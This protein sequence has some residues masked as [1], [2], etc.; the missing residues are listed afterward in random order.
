MKVIID[1]EINRDE[2]RD[3][4]K[5]NDFSTPFQTPEFFDFFN[6]VPG[7][8]ASVFA[9]YS[10][11]Q[12]KVIS[13]VTMQKEIGLFS[14]FSRR[15]IIY[16][17]PVV[18]R[19]SEIELETLFSYIN[20]ALKNKIIYLE[21]RNFEDYGSFRNSF[22]KLGW[23]YYPH[24][25]IQIKLAGKSLDSLF[26]EMKYNR[27]REIRISLKE[28][29]IYKE[30]ET[31]DEVIL[32]YSIL[33]ELYKNR[34]NLPLPH[35]KYFTELFHSSVGKV[36]LVIHNSNIIGGCFCIY[37][38]NVSI[39]TLY[40]CGLRNYH[41]KIFPTHLAI[42]AAMD[43]GLKNNL[44]I[45]DMMGAGKPGINYGVRNYKSEFGGDLVEN[46]RF[47]KIYDHFL[48]LIGRIGIRLMK[49]FK[50]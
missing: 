49:S 20:G 39:F 29:A 43:F 4:L 45:L 8:T 15:A 47:M 40:Y 21:T 19:N 35:V 18:A 37:Y 12:I 9:I 10:N 5:A 30:A 13:V 11:Q 38:P 33:F 36:F 42:I 25:N 22:Q 44:N 17:G 50:R 2:W 24:L 28:G 27:K 32:L 26:N 14:Y 46:G 23:K 31:E 41:N 3:F 34:V 48:F 1:N 16:G 7:Q 6:K